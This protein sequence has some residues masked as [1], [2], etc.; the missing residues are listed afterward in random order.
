MH[1]TLSS[2]SLLGMSLPY[3]SSSPA[4]SKEKRAECYAAGEA[5]KILLQKDIKPR[6]IMTKAAFENAIRMI[7]MTGGS[8]N[9][10]LHLIAMSRA[11]QDPEVA[12][13]LGDFQ[14]ISDIV[15]LRIVAVDVILLEFVASIVL[16]FGVACI[17][18]YLAL[19]FFLDSIFG[20]LEAIWKIRHGGCPK[21]WWYSRYDQVFD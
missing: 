19:P 14:R 2:S 15:S 20:R 12:I 9:A 21:H 7:M 10:V 16:D 1:L 3:S 6:D 8:T 11:C 17:L 13:A 4:D 5:M 18:P